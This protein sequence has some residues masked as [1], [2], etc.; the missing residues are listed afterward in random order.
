M[1]RQIRNLISDIQLGFFASRSASG[2]LQRH[3]R[4][5]ALLKHQKSLELDFLENRELLAVDIVVGD[6][7]FRGDLVADADVY[8]AASKPIEV[9]YNPTQGEEFRSLVTLTGNVMVDPTA[10]QFQ[11][12]GTGTFDTSNG[13]VPFWQ[14]DSTKTYNVA[15]VETSGIS[16]T[17]PS[18]QFG[19]LNA[20]A[21]SLTLENPNGGDTTDA[22]AKIGGSGELEFGTLANGSDPNDPLAINTIA[23]TVTGPDSGLA[24]GT[25][26]GTV[27]VS[28]TTWVLQE[29]TLTATMT[30]GVCTTSITG[31]AEATL[32]GDKLSATLQNTGLVVSGGSIQ[33]LDATV[34][35]GTKFAGEA[36]QIQGTLRLAN[37]TLSFSGNGSL[38]LSGIATA[39]LDELTFSIQQDKLIALDVPTVNM[40]NI[41]F[42]NLMSIA[43][44]SKIGVDF[45]LKCKLK[46]DAATGAESLN[47][48]GSAVGSYSG[49][50]P[51]SG[52][53]ADQLSSYIKVTLSGDGLVIRDG[54]VSDWQ[55]QVDGRL[56]LAKISL[57]MR[58]FTIFH[59]ASDNSYGGFGTFYFTLDGF[60]AFKDEYKNL[61]F[62][63]PSNFI[64]FE[65]GTSM[66]SP[67]L[68]F[69]DGQLRRLDANISTKN[70]PQSLNLGGYTFRINKLGVVYV[71]DA[72]RVTQDWGVYGNISLNNRKA[73]I[74]D[75]KITK[76]LAGNLLDVPFKYPGGDQGVAV[77]V[78]LGTREAPGL[79]IQEK[80]NAE[81]DRDITDWSLNST[82]FRLTG[83]YLGPLRISEL[84]VIFSYNETD[85]L[86]LDHF[87]LTMGW[88]GLMLGGSITFKNVEDPTTGIVERAV[89][90]FT[91]KAGIDPGANKAVSLANSGLPIIPGY[92]SLMYMVGGVSNLT[93]PDNLIINV[94]ATFILGKDL[95]GW[96]G[97]KG[98][99]IYTGI[100]VGNVALDLGK[101]KITG[102]VNAYF[103]AYWDEANYAAKLNPWKPLLGSMTGTFTIDWANN[104]YELDATGNLLQLVNGKFQLKINSSGF[105]LYAMVQVKPTPYGKFDFWPV[106][107]IDVAGHF[108]FLKTDSQFVAGAWAVIHVLAWDETIGVAYDILN[109]EISLIGEDEAKTLL[110]AKDNYIS[111]SGGSSNSLPYTLHEPVGLEQGTTASQAS[112]ITV[113]LPYLVHTTVSVNPSDD[114]FNVTIPNLVE[115]SFS[116]RVDTGDNNLWGYINNYGN[117]STS[118]PMYYHQGALVIDI[119]ANP[120]KRTDYSKIFADL[121]LKD[122]AITINYAN[123]MTYNPI[124]TTETSTFERLYWNRWT[125]HSIAYSSDGNYDPT[126]SI[127]DILDH[128]ENRPVYPILPTAIVTPDIAPAGVSFVNNQLIASSPT[129]STNVTNLSIDS[130]AS[131][132]TK[133]NGAATLMVVD[134]AAVQASRWMVMQTGTWGN[135]SADSGVT[136]NYV[137][138]GAVVE[139]NSFNAFELIN[140]LADQAFT[141]GAET[142]GEEVLFLTNMGGI[143]KGKI[144][145]ASIA[146]NSVSVQTDDGTI[147]QPDRTMV[148]PL[149]SIKAAVKLSTNYQN[150][151][152]TLKPW[153]VCTAANVP[154]GYS[155]ANAASGRSYYELFNIHSAV[156]LG[157]APLEENAVLSPD[158]FKLPTLP[159]FVTDAQNS[160]GHGKN[161]QFY[162]IDDSTG[163][164]TMPAGLPVAVTKVNGKSVGTAD[165]P[166]SSIAFS[167]LSLNTAGNTNV[168]MTWS[169]GSLTPTPKFAYML[170][171]DGINTPTYSSLNKFTPSLSL[172][173][174]VMVDQGDGTLK[175]LVGTTVYF[176][177]NGNG[178]YDQTEP[179]T[180]V[181]QDGVFDTGDTFADMN[182]NGVRDT[183]DE[184]STRVNSLGQYYFYDVNPGNYKIG[185]VLPGNKSPVSGSD[186]ISVTRGSE[187]LT[188]V[189]DFVVSNIYPT[190]TGRVVV[191]MNHNAIADNSEKGLGG[192][193]VVATGAD[194]LTTQVLTDSDGNYQISLD[195]PAFG[196]SVSISVL[197][198]GFDPNLSVATTDAAK[199]S[200]QITGID[201]NKP[202]TFTQDVIVQTNY[203]FNW[204]TSQGFFQ[205]IASY[206][207]AFLDADYTGV[208]FKTDHFEFNVDRFKLLPFS[209]DQ[210][211]LESAAGSV[212]IAG[213]KVNFT[214]NGPNG[215]V[216]SGPKLQSLNLSLS[217][218]LKIFGADLRLDGLTV[219]YTAAEEELGTP[220]SF[221]L[222]GSTTLKLGEN[223]LTVNLPGSGLVLSKGGIESLN[224]KLSGGLKIGGNLIDVGSLE[225][226]YSKAMDKLTLTGST[227]LLG[228]GSETDG[229]FLGLDHVV[230]QIG[231]AEGLRQARILSLQAKVSGGLTFDK[232]SFTVDELSVTYAPEADTLNITG[233]STLSI[234]ESS[235][236]LN[237]PAPG[238]EVAGGKV[239]LLATA[240]GELKTKKFQFNLESSSLSYQ[241]KALRFAINGSFYVGE[242]ELAMGG[243]ELAWKGGALSEISGQVSGR[244]SLKKSVVRL[245][246]LD[247]G[248]VADTQLFTLAGAFGVE[249]KQAG[250]TTSVLSVNGTVGL[251]EGVVSSVTGQIESGT[252]TVFKN[253][254]VD[255]Q[256]LNLDYSKADAS[257]SISGEARAELLGS[258]VGL[259]LTEPGIVWQDGAFGSF[260]GGLTGSI[261][262]EKDANGKTVSDIYAKN[263]GFLY[264]VEGNRLTLQGTLGADFGSVGGGSLQT[265]SK[266]LIID[267]GGLQRFSLFVSAGL[268]FGES[269]KDANG[270][271]IHQ[272]NEK[273]TDA[274]GNGRYDFGFAIN[275]SQAG[276]SFTPATDSSPAE[277]VLS[278]KGQLGFGPDLFV[279]NN[280]VGA[281]IDFTNPGI[282]IVGGQVQDFSA[283]VGGNLSLEGMELAGTAALG[284][285]WIAS[286]EEFDL[287]G[288]LGVTI[289]ENTYGL[290]LGT[291]AAPG[292]SIVQSVLTRFDAGISG[293]VILADVGFTLKD[294]GLSWD[295]TDQAWGIYGGL[296][297][298][299]GVWV[300]AG[301]GTPGQPGL[302]INTTD[303]NNARWSLNALHLG[304]G[305]L[306]LGGFGIDQVQ[307]DFS[308]VD[309]VVSVVASCGV[310]FDG[311]GLA[312]KLDFSNGVINQIF[313]Q[314]NTNIIV[315]GTPLVINRLAGSIQNIDFNNLSQ[316][317]FTAMVGVNVGGEVDLTGVP[318]ISGKYG[319][320]QFNGTAIIS[321][322]GMT[323]QADAYIIAKETGPIG[324]SKWKGYL[325]SGTAA[326][327]LNWADKEYFANL[328]LTLAAPT[329]PLFEARIRGLMSFDGEAMGFSLYASA[330]LQLSSLIPMIGGWEI[331]GASFLMEI[332]PGSKLIDTLA[333]FTYKDPLDWMK[334]KNV[335]LE[336]DLWNNKWSTLNDAE[337]KSRLK[338]RFG[339]ASF[340]STA[341][342]PAPTMSLAALPATALSGS[343]RL[344]QA[345]SVKACQ[346]YS[347][348]SSPVPDTDVTEGLYTVKFQVVDPAAQAGSQAWLGKLKLQVD[349]VAGVQIETLTPT[350]DPITGQGAIAVRLLPLAGQ[351]LPRGFVFTSHLV[352]PIALA[353]S[354]VVIGQNP[355]QLQ[356]DSSWNTAFEYGG[357]LPAVG[358]DA[359]TGL[360]IADLNATQAT[361]VIHFKPKPAEG[362]SLPADWLD[363]IRAYVP[364]VTGAEVQVGRA[365][366]DEMS[367]TGSI[368]IDLLPTG[369]ATFLLSGIVPEVIL[370]SKIALTGLNG[371]GQPDVAG[372]WAAK[373]SEI[374]KP[375]IP[376]VFGTGLRTT[377][378]TGR[379][380]DPRHKQ[381]RV[382][383]FYSRDEAGNNEHLTTLADGSQAMNIPVTVQDDGTWSVDVTWDPSNLPGGH[384][385]LYGWVDD[386][387]PYE[388]V[389]GESA[390]FT[391]QHDV[392]GTVLSPVAIPARAVN[393][394]SPFSERPPA[395]TTPEPGVR[396]FADINGNGREDQGE[397]VAITDSAGQYFLDV[398][399]H[400]RPVAIV[401]ETPYAF[402]PAAG[403]SATRVVD[404]ARGPAQVNLNMVPTMTIL[405]G[406]VKVAG[407]AG[408][409]VGG[410]G[411]VATGPDGRIYRETTDIQGNFDIP[412]STPGLYSVNLDG[413]KNLFYTFRVSPAPESFPTQVNVLKQAPRVIDL[414][415]LNVL[416]TGIVSLEG[417]NAQGTL[418]TL[419]EESNA[420]FV[421]DVGFDASMQGKT[422]A[423]SGVAPAL[424]PPYLL[425]N[426]STQS[427]KSI[428]ASPP[429]GPDG[430]PD[431][432]YLYGRNGFV[433]QQ[434]LRIDGGHL[435]ITLQGDGSFRAFLVRP[436]AVFGLANLSISGFGATGANGL[437]GISGPAG[438]AS[439]ATGGQAGQGGAIFN[440]GDTTIAD[441]VFI[442]NT[443]RGGDGGSVGVPLPGTPASENGRANNGGSGGGA[444]GGAGGQAYTV[445]IGYTLAGD[446]ATQTT[447][448]EMAGAGGG[449]SGLGGAIYNASAE[450]LLSIKG[451]T[452]FISNK[453]I[454][455]K[456]GTVPDYVTNLANAIAGDQART[457][458]SSGFAGAVL[459]RGQNG[460]GLGDS[461]FN[462]GGVV[463]IETSYAPAIGAPTGISLSSLR[464]AENNAPGAVVGRL[465]TTAGATGKVA[466]Q[467]V[468][469]PGSDDNR[470]FSIVDGQLTANQ[471]FNYELQAAFTVRVRA[472]VASGLY[473]D[474][475]YVISVVDRK[476]AVKP[477]V[478]LPKQFTAAAE[479][480]SPLVFTNAP[481]VDLVARASQVFTV[482]MRVR[483]GSLAAES[484]SDVSVS[485]TPTSLVF[486]G[487]LSALNA[488]FTSLEGRVRYTPVAHSTVSRVIQLRISKI[489]GAKSH[490][491]AAQGRIVIAKPMRIACRSHFATAG[492]T[493]HVNSSTTADQRQTTSGALAKPG[494]RSQLSRL[495]RLA[496]EPR[497]PRALH[498]GHK[499]L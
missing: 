29:K 467:L 82:G 278:G 147:W 211:G 316:L 258:T 270:D 436:G 141:G 5:S 32:R 431:D 245:D 446:P 6:L 216:A 478:T 425:W 346:T 348:S 323:I 192:V 117:V 373:P 280:A 479:G 143:K 28:A 392:E 354:A 195:D 161:D 311:W 327:T 382:A 319:I 123:L 362:Q 408:Q 155:E 153:Q 365:S 264:E 333:W 86:V 437:A 33:S 55:F 426:S 471:S 45:D 19:D 385:W 409:P 330:T 342:E 244:L 50:K 338:G 99:T 247:A 257:F 165:S 3:K 434:K 96:D 226:V 451:N 128:S 166:A 58:S 315:P 308:Q 285:R 35:G 205:N 499:T 102:S 1:R 443:A 180:D 337:V 490:T 334:E 168:S 87:G 62:R 131:I 375:V 56:D 294:A 276:F 396:V 416:T 237:L 67:G 391:L 240:T 146:N 150:L 126:E 377:T 184:L 110:T 293:K 335:G 265:D 114:K 349:S 380:N 484:T 360:P 400:S 176:D 324:S 2:R 464:I 173:G 314:A 169:E 105:V 37:D 341:L 303:P 7:L 208:S 470:S 223:T 204:D 302:M 430:Q 57:E 221:S 227:N 292:M 212:V 279:K 295:T 13:Q 133:N 12:K 399:D 158:W 206:F 458:S 151:A 495:L 488:Y 289:S 413:E 473:A 40:T 444:Y 51:A 290:T 414:G 48:T 259:S 142:V 236:N 94:Q 407:N 59:N 387:G 215:L 100:V 386:S 262:L 492:A 232:A 448:V 260:G 132:Y 282:R 181:N 296:K 297:I 71:A 124:G 134:E 52:A 358:T 194:G 398:A 38:D 231:L 403:Q 137:A 498:N 148:K 112:H 251:K 312:G 252:W 310:E 253:F 93:D 376:A 468:F 159:H 369:G 157:N 267:S 85:G 299:L 10:G 406:H 103:G 27:Y 179:Y 277:L 73:S 351:Y 389:Y 104:N 393:A 61:K 486:K 8:R 182:N 116:Y 410:V 418:Q 213:Q 304:F 272:E 178:Q 307:F 381:V 11:F 60:K 225:C 9:G 480:A 228:F 130:N 92:L 322:G 230:M 210:Q 196:S 424:D 250:T 53:A 249:L 469:G 283:G 22:D 83:L 404:L 457:L 187:P 209:L 111:G 496:S 154:T 191:D 20:T 107:Q 49:A 188:T 14:N 300:E 383:L 222:S 122:L 15:Q 394:E 25:V 69:V 340:H 359:Q 76:D 366:Y 81:L 487:T 139:Q 417:D 305:G 329:N 23:I 36:S 39:T 363:S 374:D 31:A 127:T 378:L 255:L 106:N 472:T 243:G 395:I 172:Q 364:A 89:D 145:A 313:V 47:I 174:R 433:V 138:N 274:N 120:D 306:D 98:T 287:W 43:S 361:Y 164:T 218:D 171:S 156:T 477:I 412:V 460:Q 370:R 318:L 78:N 163:L 246:N 193:Y 317:T 219:L 379:V 17:G 339:A 203:D 239:S 454:E 415:E 411:V 372:Q 401:I 466:Y 224:I 328:D 140:R 343:S 220:A 453:T 72:G 275:I 345:A 463:N 367:Q 462:N 144:T 261:P 185:F 435:G 429:V 352:S 66:D 91:V 384:L 481:F 42:A 24:T 170:V 421:T 16:I 207:Q 271:Y 465:A 214:L 347:G 476:E 54:E 438:G 452:R 149:W 254:T 95:P 242:T 235:L 125:S 353:A 331:A 77:G 483:V 356:I 442:N 46:L 497:L 493:N 88:N 160:P 447:R 350:Y 198:A 371:Y 456:G 65:A 459:A 233:Q 197:P 491:S 286:Q 284:A 494:N 423:V 445:T 489:E 229:N 4:Q 90:A 309:G 101:N 428:P 44:L 199:A 422:L 455:G 461:I 419:V 152:N 432:T 420:G 325:A 332:Y 113:T 256:A 64:A 136:D 397:P 357:T 217:G 118:T 190:I 189:P 18:F 241:D 390:E 263:L 167:D 97:V 200:Q 30:G 450:S 135:N 281:T 266:G 201:F 355:G 109:N 449:G 269:F 440:M 441:V 115:G 273:Y 63:E 121:N 368:E 68:L 405:S 41:G 238:I 475:V 80:Y 234:G 175:P 26:S 301:L 202:V 70:G 482:S 439:G 320:A 75:G 268:N 74:E 321:A 79:L 119:Y 248:Y 162:P 326:V 485:G 474:Q 388:P 129:S 288:G 427:W 177:T 108:L 291:S 344:I 186:I 336:W 402:A 183:Y 34:S 298:D 21:T 84:E